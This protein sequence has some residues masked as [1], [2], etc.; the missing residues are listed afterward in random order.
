MSATTI[1]GLKGFANW[2]MIQ[3]QKEMVHVMKIYDYINDQDGR[4]TLITIAQLPTEF[5]LPL[6]MFEKTLG[7]RSS[8]QK[9]SMI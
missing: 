3:Y 6:D 9:V 5:G 2:F 7:T 4:V 8:L 1:I